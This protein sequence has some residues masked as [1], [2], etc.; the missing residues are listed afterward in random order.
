MWSPNP[1]TI[2]ACQILW[3][4]HD[5][6][7]RFESYMTVQIA[8]YEAETR[9]MREEVQ[10]LKTKASFVTGR[11]QGGLEGTK[12]QAFMAGDSLDQLRERCTT[13]FM[14]QRWR[15]PRSSGSDEKGKGVV[16]IMMSILSAGIGTQEVSPIYL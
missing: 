14:V 6:C 15:G 2:Y 13:S 12:G 5:V 10:E 11:A 4:T 7:P 3:R 16:E 8:K 9:A 1:L